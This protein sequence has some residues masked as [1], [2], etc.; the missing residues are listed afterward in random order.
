MCIAVLAIWSATDASFRIATWQAMVSLRLQSIRSADPEL[1]DA[2]GI[3]DA[4]REIR[5][6]SIGKR[7]IGISLLSAIGIAATVGTFPIVT[8]EFTLKRGVVSGTVLI[9]WCVLYG[10]HSAV[11]D[12][13]VKR[14]VRAQF[15]RFETVGLALHD[16]WP[17]ESGELLPGLKFFTVPEKYP[18]ILVLRGPRESYP[19]HE[20][21]GL[22]INRGQ[23]GIIRFDLSGAYDST[24]EFHPNGTV[25]TAYTSG[26]GN[27]SPSVAS[28]IRLKDRWFLVR[29]AGFS[30]N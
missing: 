1:L 22:M 27:P 5:W 11:D 4:M 21:F 2:T 13:R 7:A 17:T 19:F 14:Q 16:Q 25:P 24:V 30:P 9:A 26:F 6:N 15:P 12:W 18:G 10:T 20:D 28:V 8:R 29:Y 23:N 3:I